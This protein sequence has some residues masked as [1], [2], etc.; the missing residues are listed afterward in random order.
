M[1]IRLQVAG[2]GREPGEQERQL[3]EYLRSQDQL[4]GRVHLIA[5]RRQ[6]GGLSQSIAAVVMELT[7]AGLLAF[8][9]ALVAWIRHKTADTKVIVHRPDGTKF[10][11]SAQ[12]I[13]GLGADKL[14]ALTQQIADTVGKDE[15][16]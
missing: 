14:A 10:E 9:S 11:I 12:R 2:S 15:Q 7:P 5:E 16:K 1:R 3:A 13:R 6:S 4:R 8:A